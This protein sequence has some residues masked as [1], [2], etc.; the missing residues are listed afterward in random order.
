[1]S[2]L[3][4]NKKALDKRAPLKGVEKAPLRDQIVKK[5]FKKV[6]DLDLGS[7]IIK[8]WHVESSNIAELLDRQQAYLADLD[9][10]L[11]NQAEGEFDGS[12]NLKIPMPTIVSK[13][14]IARFFQALWSID[15]PFN[16]KARRED[17]VEKVQLV[18]D[19]MRYTIYHWA[20]HYK[21]IDE[22][23]ELW[24]AN[25]VNQGTGILKTRWSQE[26]CSFVD[27]VKEP[28]AGPP[29][30]AID[31]NG[32]EVA[33]PTTVLVEKEQTI[34]IPKFA[35]PIV[36]PVQMEDFIM[37][38]GGG[39]PDLADMVIHRYYMTESELWGMVDE[40]KFD[41]A[42]VEATIQAG[43]QRLSSGL[44]QNIKQQRSE[45]AGKASL[46][47]TNALDRYEIL[48]TYLKACVDDSGI[49]SDLIVWIGAVAG[50]PLRATYLYRVIP[51][52]ERPF[53]VIHF[54]KR[55][56]QEY[57]TGLL[58][59][60]HPL[61]VELN[62]LH[63]IKLDHGMITANPIFFYRSSSSFQPEKLQVEPGMGIPVDNPQTDVVFPNRPQNSAFFGNEEQLI[64]VYIERLTGISDL[65]LGAMAGS[66]GA[67]RT[68][69]GARALLSESNTNLDIHL[70]HLMRG[71]KKILSLLF[72][73]L[74]QRLDGQFQFRITGQDGSDVFKQVSSYDLAFDVDFEI[75]PNSANSNKSVQ[76]ENAQQ[77]VAITSNPLYLQLGVTGP[78]QVYEALKSL[79]NALGIKDV[80]RYINKP[81]GYAYA[82]SPE[83]VFNR[84]VRGISVDPNPQMDID[85]IVAFMQSMVEQQQK[86]DQPILSQDQIIATINSMRK[87]QQFKQALD[88][89]AA[90]VQVAQQM[91]ANAVASQNQAPTGLNPMAGSMGGE[92]QQGGGLPI[93]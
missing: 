78:G 61:T 25:W 75:A 41:E 55:P 11:P 9:E 91:Q 92:S 33:V 5:L 53:S 79:L 56:G 86:S 64:Q 17:G 13:A 52:G 50:K 47:T 60:L 35:G 62:A 12:S 49:D 76:L 19:F 85:G 46:D 28:A 20:N 77:L 16:V 2:I 65:S 10:H 87:F 82:L 24:L 3:P 21:G 14:Y 71:W 80:H 88:Q 37:V 57:G 15:P 58:E 72:H 74:Q 4:N 43:P 23:V 32:K 54:H 44:N 40:G 6:E 38:G 66:Q 8:A 18:E 22:A 39:D 36:E 83:E 81:Q 89:Q 7:R 1:M 93:G 29:R 26:Y 63:N 45:I 67:A 48:E 90:Q 68:A 27:A 42:A 59:L 30:F 51:T 73:M 84:A 31:G 69:T 34:T 70:R